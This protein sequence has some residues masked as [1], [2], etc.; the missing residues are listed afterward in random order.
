[1]GGGGSGNLR[2]WVNRR[3][4]LLL[5]YPGRL[6]RLLDKAQVEKGVGLCTDSK[7]CGGLLSGHANVGG[8]RE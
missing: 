2:D 4:C 8:V 5:I 7:G 3:P 1:M 6:A